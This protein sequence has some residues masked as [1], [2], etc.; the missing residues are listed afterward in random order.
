MADTSPS[1]AILSDRVRTG[2]IQL[3]GQFSI[4]RG[5]GESRSAQ[6]VRHIARGIEQG[7]LP[8]GAPL[9]STRGLARALGVSRNT[10]LTAYD[11]L[12]A[13][14]LVCGRRG[15]WIRVA[16]TAGVQGFDLRQVMRDAQYPSRT[17]T[18]RDPDGNPLYVSY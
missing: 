11:E 5:S 2:K 12:K 10:V 13:R 8:S 4:D 1:R 18:L 6:I 7:G 17:V 15:A 3:K 16:A 14:G 9:P